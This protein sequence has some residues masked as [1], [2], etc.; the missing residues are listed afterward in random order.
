M[1]TMGARRW[2][3]VT[4]AWLLACLVWAGPDPAQ[5]AWLDRHPDNRVEMITNGTLLAGAALDCLLQRGLCLR[6]SGAG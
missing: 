4:L 6:V 3:L 1:N 5:L 2:L